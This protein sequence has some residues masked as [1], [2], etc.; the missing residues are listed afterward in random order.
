MRR[1]INHRPKSPVPVPDPEPIVVEAEA[2]ESE[3]VKDM[4]PF[5]IS[6]EDEIINY[7]KDK[8][9]K[10]TLKS[11]APLLE[12]LEEAVK[13]HQAY[14]QQPAATASPVP[15]SY[16]EQLKKLQETSKVKI[17][18]KELKITERMNKLQMRFANMRK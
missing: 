7:I 8:A 12:K 2:V 4:M 13:Q 1:R 5:V 17:R 11:L 10:E 3:V 15:M 18:E 6:N 14:Q 16:E 9:T